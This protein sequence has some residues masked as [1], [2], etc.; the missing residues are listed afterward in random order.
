MANKIA[1]DVTCR[2]LLANFFVSEQLRSLHFAAVVEMPFK[3]IPEFSR[4]KTPET[5][6][7]DDR[8]GCLGPQVHTPSRN[9]GIRPPPVVAFTKILYR[10]IL[11]AHSVSRTDVVTFFQYN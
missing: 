10:T 4:G 2:S 7:S 3:A 5:Q 11:Y 9:I 8:S 6:F 1:F